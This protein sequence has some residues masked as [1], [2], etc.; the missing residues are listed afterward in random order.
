M[1][2]LIGLWLVGL[3]LFALGILVWSKWGEPF[4]GLFLTMFSVALLSIGAFVGAPSEISTGRPLTVIDGGQ[5][6]VA[7]VYV[8]GENVNVGIEKNGEGDNKS[9][10]LFLYQFPK[11][12]FDSGSIN[13]KATKL[14]VVESGRFWNKFRKLILE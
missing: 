1:V 12:A 13:P 6:K 10:H 14:V 4:I 3:V 11:S 5:Y 7:F 8:A 9:E 2:N